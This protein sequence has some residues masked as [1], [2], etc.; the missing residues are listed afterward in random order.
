MFYFEINTQYYG[1][2]KI[3]LLFLE[4]NITF[5]FN[6]LPFYKP[7]LMFSSTAIKFNW[8]LF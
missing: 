8:F 1:S 4:S 6:I 5:T 2:L 7:E 3:S